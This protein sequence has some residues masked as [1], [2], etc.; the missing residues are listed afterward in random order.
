M[1]RALGIDLGGTKIEAAV[2]EVDDSGLRTLARKRTETNQDDGYQAILATI[3]RLTSEVIEEAGANVT[4]T[5]MGIPGSL[6]NRGLVRNANSLVLNGRRLQEDV[7]AIFER[8]VAIENDANCFALAEA[9]WGAAKDVS[10]VF[11]VIMGTGVG[12]G[13]VVD[14]NIWRGSQSIA[15]EWGHNTLVSGG[16][17][18]WCGK[19]GCV[20]QYLSGPAIENRFAQKTGKSWPLERIVRAANEDADARAT[21]DQLHALFGIGISSIANLLDPDVIVIGGGLSQIESLY[22]E[23]KKEAER[24][25]F[26]PDGKLELR[27]PAL[28]DSA[29]VFGAAL[30]GIGYMAAH[31]EP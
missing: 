12:G 7:E 29:G 6:D 11:G 27:R 16:L 18:C 15:G 26:C 24:H 2:V 20:E 4:S 25:L 28:G 3:K 21:L 8:P 5:G 1:H 23:G 30:L 13:I 10:V 9:R 14:G 22:G 17:P 31:E 19:Q